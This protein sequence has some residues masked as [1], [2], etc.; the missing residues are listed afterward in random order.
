MWGDKKEFPGN[1]KSPN[2][3]HFTRIWPICK[4]R[5][6]TSLEKFP[7]DR[8]AEKGRPPEQPLQ[9]YAPGLRRPYH[10]FY[11]LY[12][13]SPTRV[14]VL[15]SAYYSWRI[16]RSIHGAPICRDGWG[17]CAQVYPSESANTDAEHAKKPGIP[18]I[19]TP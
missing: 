14:A 6:S 3:E 8:L 18:P 15:V 19:L 10:A 12:S 11:T 4:S 16:L 1:R 17:K 5:K 7:R 13:H 2:F 9:F